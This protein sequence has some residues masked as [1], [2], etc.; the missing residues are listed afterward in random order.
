MDT[1]IVSLGRRV[2]SSNDRIHKCCALHNCSC[3]SRK[4]IMAF[5]QKYIENIRSEGFKG[6][7]PVSTLRLKE[8]LNTVPLRS[9]VYLVLNPTQEKPA[10][11][12]KSVGGHYEGKD[13]T[14]ILE[15]L[16]EN[17]VDGAKLLYIG[18]TTKPEQTLHKRVSE[19]I[20]FGNGKKYSHWGGRLIW[21]L[22]NHDALLICWRVDKNP[23]DTKCQII[24]EFKK[25]YDNALPF[26][27][28]QDPTK[29]MKSG[30]IVNSSSS[31]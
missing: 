25:K 30:R 1:C 11:L 15:F 23:V 29:H 14:V 26:A 21:Q 10:F 24:K 12:E 19:L 9:G 22:E 18:K 31:N 4:T 8:N 6:F 13:P 20:G 28:L 16:K 17:W 5:N 7:L 2:Q 27:N 3:F